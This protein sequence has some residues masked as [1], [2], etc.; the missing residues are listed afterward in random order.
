MVHMAWYSIA[1]DTYSAHVVLLCY[2]ADMVNDRFA[3]NG[4][5][6]GLWSG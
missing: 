1:C 3:A 4:F 2:V 5:G 6:L